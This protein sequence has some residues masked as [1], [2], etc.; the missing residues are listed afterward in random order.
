MSGRSGHS[1]D[2]QNNAASHVP[3]RPQTE[4][5]E[6]NPTQHFPLCFYEPMAGTTDLGPVDFSV[7]STSTHADSPSDD[8]ESF[9]DLKRGFRNIAYDIEKV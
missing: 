1:N 5:G 4:R 3:L 2:S 7:R 6:Y 9:S 8:Q